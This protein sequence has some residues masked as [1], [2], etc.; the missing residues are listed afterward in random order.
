MVNN[1]PVVKEWVTSSGLKAVILWVNGS[2]H[3]GY[4][5]LPEELYSC[6][7]TGYNGDNEFEY[8]E[9]HGGVTWQDPIHTFDNAVGFDC[10][11][12]MDKTAYNQNG[13][14]RDEEFCVEQCEHMAE[15]LKGLMQQIKPYN[16]LSKCGEAC[17][18]MTCRKKPESE[19]TKDIPQYM[20]K[21]KPVTPTTWIDIINMQL[22]HYDL[23]ANLSLLIDYETREY[24]YVYWDEA[25]QC[26]NPY[27]TYKAAFDACKRYM[28]ELAGDV[29]E[30]ATEMNENML[31]YGCIDKSK[32]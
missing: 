22:D 6:N 28:Q 1:F 25:C 5:E 26:S 11:H 16:D 3:C 15:Q 2:H 4:V 31:K 29:F 20:F 12:F 27:P 10:A 7:F 14:F 30:T 9:V 17:N 19:V 13:T 32:S 18:C 8:I 24:C 21:D 23:D